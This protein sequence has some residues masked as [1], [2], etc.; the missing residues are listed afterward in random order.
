MAVVLLE[1]ILRWACRFVEPPNRQH[2]LDHFQAT[3]A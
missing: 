2:Y 3:H 1:I